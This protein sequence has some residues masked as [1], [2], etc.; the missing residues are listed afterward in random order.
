MTWG[1]GSSEQVRGDRVGPA[2]DIYALGVVV[3]EMVAGRLPF[4]GNTPLET[5]LAR[6]E[7]EAPSP[8]E[9][10]P[11]LEVCWEAGIGRCLRRE[12]GDRFRHAEELIAALAGETPAPA[13]RPQHRLP[14]ER[15]AFVG[16]ESELAELE[17]RLEEG[18]RLV[19]LLSPGGS[20]K[21]RL[22][23]HLGWRARHH[24]NGGVWFCDPT[25]ARGWTASPRR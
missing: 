12:P 15:D 7:R 17:R 14:A 23:L 9:L 21:T 20:G 2:A 10:V 25:E 24:F 22:A 4:S 19:T 11:E 8:R 5:A 16:R 1:R 6:V 18:A 13:G 3:F